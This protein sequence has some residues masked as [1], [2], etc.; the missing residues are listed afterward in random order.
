MAAIA[1]TPAAPAGRAAAVQARGELRVCIWPEYFSITWRNPRNDELTGIDID[2]ARDLARRLGVKPVF[3]ETNFRDVMDR[4]EDGRCDVAMFGIGVTPARA[5]R[6][7]FARPYLSSAVYAVTTQ[8][9]QT[10]RRWEDID[11]PGNAVAVASGTFMEPLMRR[12]LRHATLVSV[13]P[14]HTREAELQSGRVDVFMSDFPYTRRIVTTQEWVRII[15]PPVGFGETRYA[16]AVAKGDPA[17]LAVVDDFVAAA[18]SDGTLARAA[19]R[20]GLTPILLR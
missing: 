1:Q 15:E 11:Q 12:T 20:H 17:W 16:H 2:L 7:D 13:A 4:I 18:R 6:M 14:P 19:E 5:A 9:N 3:V 10:V 8:D